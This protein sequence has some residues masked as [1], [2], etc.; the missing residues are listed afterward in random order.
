MNEAQ[1][2]RKNKI[3]LSDYDYKNDIQNRLLLSHLSTDE[4]EVL[5]EIIYIPNQFPIAL[6]AKQ[7]DKSLN[8]TLEILNALLKTNLFK[9]VDSVVVINKEKRKYFENQ[10]IKFEE[11][12]IPGIEFIQT[13][14]KKVPIHILP[15]WYPIPRT[16]NNIFHS[17]IEKYLETPQTF[18]R[19]LSELNFN[20]EKL[21]GI[22]N[23]LLSSPKYKIYSSQLKKLYTL[24][25]EEFEKHMLYLEFNFVCCIVFE[26]VNGKWV[27]MV[28]LFQEW[29]NYLNF[30]KKSKPIEIENQYQIQRHRPHDFSFIEDMSPLLAFAKKT[31]LFLDLDNKERWI[32]EKH[33]K[34]PISEQCLH[35]NLNTKEGLFFFDDYM[36]RVLQKLL[37]LKLAKIEKKQLIPSNEI[38]D[39]L[40]LPLE[41]RALTTY[42]TTINRYPFSEF[43][44]EI[45]TKRNI[46]EIE[47]SII[48]IIDMNWVFFDDF[49]RGI[50]APISEKSKMVL[51]KTG[52]HWNYT[53]PDYTH[54]EKLLI[55][56]IIY[57]WLFEGGM[58][59][60]GIF[61]GKECLK[62]TSLGKSI[63]A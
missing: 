15:T 11:K 40:T 54:E 52:R 19:Y 37:F 57:E 61:Q 49:F 38:G 9:I 53:L 3:N 21:T 17:L 7:I 13:L 36:N 32:L 46:H 5:K 47:N 24:N 6:L 34:E 42:K 45:Y 12:F 30:L 26:K 56:K 62:I 31:P 8:K 20:D 2:Y 39:W 33:F 55:R 18:Q 63:F 44:Q 41:K 4:I 10:M 25:D 16:S 59:A 29:K 51:K 27:E 14:L 23:A 28:T 22:I 35:F 60:T 50:I 1:T 58:V 48:R 43:S